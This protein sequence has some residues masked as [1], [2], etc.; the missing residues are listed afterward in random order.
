MIEKIKLNMNTKAAFRGKNATYQTIL[1]S[2]LQGLMHF[3]IGKNKE[4]SFDIPRLAIKRNDKL[5]IQ[6]RI[7]TMSPRERRKLGI[8][9]SGLWYQ[10]KKLLEGKTIKVYGSVYSKLV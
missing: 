3:V 7:L 5:D 8:S 2:N 4:F 6:Q 1:F 9:N 10:K